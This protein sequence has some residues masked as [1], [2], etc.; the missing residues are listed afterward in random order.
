M[1]KSGLLLAD[2]K[3][4]SYL[5]PIRNILVPHVGHVPWVAGLP[6]FIV[7][8]LGSLISFLARHLTQYA[9]MSSPPFLLGF[10][11]N[12]NNFPDN[13][14]RSQKLVL[15]PI[16]QKSFLFNQGHNCLKCD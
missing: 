7:M 15:L 10:V 1:V 16:E 2:G 12:I 9:C 11:C 3:V 8:D 14:N 4:C 6:F 5:L 13:V